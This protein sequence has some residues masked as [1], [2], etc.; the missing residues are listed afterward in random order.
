MLK[1]IKMGKKSLLDIIASN[2]ITNECFV[3]SFTK[4]NK[5]LIINK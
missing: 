4:K 2:Q 5:L 3:N 1:L